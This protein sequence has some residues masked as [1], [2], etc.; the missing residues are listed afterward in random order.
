MLVGV[1]RQPE[2]DRE[3]YMQYLKSHFLK[4][5]PHGFGYARLIKERINHC[6]IVAHAV[7]VFAD[8]MASI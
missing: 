7:K 6:L 3:P 8:R 5:R 1:Y 4:E 2:T